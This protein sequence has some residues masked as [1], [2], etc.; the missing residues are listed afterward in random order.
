MKRKEAANGAEAAATAA[1][2]AA[3]DIAGGAGGSSS[4]VSTYAGQERVELSSLKGL[5][6]MVL[7]SISFCDPDVRKDLFSSVLLTGGNSLLPNLGARLEKELVALG[8]QTS[9]IKVLA[10]QAQL[11]RRF[12][13]WIGGSI[14]ASLGSFQQMWLS[15]AEYD[16]NGAQLIHRKAP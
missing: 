9:K 5:Q 6:S 11:E 10:Q 3:N 16:E 13:A 15:K 7:D 4:K 2:A 12:S 14:L 8:P 1:A